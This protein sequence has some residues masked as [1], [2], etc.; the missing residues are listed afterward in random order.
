MAAQHN[1]ASCPAFLREQHARNEAVR[2]HALAQQIPTDRQG[3]AGFVNLDVEDLP[4]STE[5][6]SG[7]AID[8]ATIFGDEFTARRYRDV[9]LPPTGQQD[10]TIPRTA[11]QKRAHVKV[12]FQAFKSVPS[13]STEG[14]KMKEKFVKEEHNNHLVE[15]M[16]WELLGD[17]IQ[18]AEKA[19]NLVEAWEPGKAKGKTEEWTFAERFDHLVGA[20]AESKAICKHLFDVPFRVKLVDDPLRSSK[21][22]ASNRVLNQKKAESLKRGREAE[23]EDDKKAKRQATGAQVDNNL[24]LQ[25]IQQQAQQFAFPQH[26]APQTPQP[27]GRNM[28]PTGQLP[29]SELRRSANATARSSFSTPP[30][31]IPR[32]SAPASNMRPSFPAQGQQYGSPPG[33][34]RPYNVPYGHGSAEMQAIFGPPA[35]LGS[36]P[37]I[38]NGSGAAIPLPPQQLQGFPGPG[39]AQ[40]HF[41]GSEPTHL[42]DDDPSLDPNARFD[43][44]VSRVLTAEEQ[45]DLSVFEP[46]YPEPAASR[47]A[48]AFDPST[49]SGTNDTEDEN[50]PAAG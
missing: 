31:G 40:T 26:G 47:N 45:E 34:R 43:D 8:S 30:Q 9:L 48:R 21:R 38:Y 10:G 23:K 24:A 29:Q 33:Q 17:L 39:M 2:I 37:H 20:M 15:V 6:M 12:L 1:R 35:P 25:A 27:M 28:G 22:V 44:G 46:Y 18:R 4:S 11:E 16:C 5:L 19:V 14:E 3:V 13:A 36:M 7:Q 50:N 32:S 41:Q 49:P 42:E